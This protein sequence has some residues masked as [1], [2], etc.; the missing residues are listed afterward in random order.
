MDK[1]TIK[2]IADVLY[3][4][5]IISLEEYEDI[6]SACTPSCLDKIVE[7]MLREDYNNYKAARSERGVN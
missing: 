1:I 3:V 2:F 4:K 6:M 7:R 5:A